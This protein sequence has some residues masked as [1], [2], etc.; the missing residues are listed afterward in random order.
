MTSMTLMVLGLVLFIGM[1]LV[2]TAP[3]LRARLAATLGE[4]PYK[5]LFAIVSAAGLVL[6]VI[7]WPGTPERVALFTPV[8][9]ARA[10]SPLVVTLA[11]ILFAAANLNAHIRATLRHPMLIGLLLWAGVH[12]LAN[13]DVAGTVLFGSF[14]VYALVA[15][16]SAESRHAIKP[17]L[18]TWKHDAIA[19]GAGLL[20]SYLVMRFHSQL[21]GT[22]SVL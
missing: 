8:P 10:A 13:G 12:L 1:H 4:R 21:F 19:V 18:P 6:I 5:G 7:G 14:A 16:A 20:I 17:V 22:P 2:P 15:I 3:S 11:I 9:A